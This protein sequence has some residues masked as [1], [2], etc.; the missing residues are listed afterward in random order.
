MYTEQPNQVNSFSAQGSST[1]DNRY[2]LR[3]TNMVNVPA[4]TWRPPLIVTATTPA[5][6]L[7]AF[8]R[9]F[10]DLQ[11]GSIW[12][13]VAAEL[14]TVQGA[15]LDVG[16]GAQPFRPLL[17]PGTQY[18][19]IDTTDAKAHFGY[20]MPDTLYF[21]G[22]I[23]PLEDRSV[24][25]ILCTETLEHLPD[26]NVLLREAA[27]VL[28]SGGRMIMTVPF[29]ARW[30]FIPHDYWR[31][32]P[33]SLKNLLETNGFEHIAIFA[34]GNALT[35]ACYKTMALF[36]PLLFGRPANA[37]WLVPSRLLGIVC[38]P[39][40]LALA[41]LGNLSQ[42]SKGGNDCLGYTVLSERK[43]V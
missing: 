5:T 4:E 38:L 20:E 9:R 15:V 18:I 42:L 28:R 27:R 21:S 35:V 7:I 33:S 19:G 1:D 2:T 3:R 10:L 8:V 22:V 25:V 24:D 30:H 32:T 23:W 40:V 31:Y 36:L 29:A 37:V 16:C 34:R 6:Q 26:P 13:D 14:A 43:E 11:L 12:C 17:R 39:L 41:M